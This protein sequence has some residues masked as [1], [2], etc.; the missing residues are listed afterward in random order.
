MISLSCYSH[1]RSIVRT[2]PSFFFQISI[3]MF[4]LPISAGH[5]TKIWSWAGNLM[6][7]EVLRKHKH[8]LSC[9]RICMEML[10]Y[11]I[12]KANEH[13]TEDSGHK[14]S[15]LSSVTRHQAYTERIKTILVFFPKAENPNS[16]EQSSMW[17]QHVQLQIKDLLNIFL[18][19]AKDHNLCKQNN[20]KKKNVLGLRVM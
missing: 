17:F 3:I 14:W 4:F 11:A 13:N 5:K 19:T 10:R 6:R 7:N 9:G 18:N 15:F 16:T 12:W 20:N 8:F 1:W 2:W